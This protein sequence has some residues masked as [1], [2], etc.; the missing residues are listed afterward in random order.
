[1]RNDRAAGKRADCADYP[2]QTS[3]A[4]WEDGRASRRGNTKGGPVRKHALPEMEACSMIPNWLRVKTDYAGVTT[5]V[6]FGL[7]D[8]LASTACA[9][10]CCCS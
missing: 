3:F 8:K 10:Q 7:L 5:L 6:D 4:G 1:M 9:T 2:A